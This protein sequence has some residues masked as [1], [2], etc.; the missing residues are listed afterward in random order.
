MPLEIKKAKEKDFLLIIR[1]F[2]ADPLSFLLWT[3]S[4][5]EFENAKAALEKNLKESKI[6]CFSVFL[7]EELVG[8][9]ELHHINRKW[10]RL[11]RFVVDPKK[12]RRG[13]GKWLINFLAKKFRST[14]LLRLDLVVFTE[15]YNAIRLYEGCGFKTEGILKNVGQVEGRLLN[16]KVMS[17]LGNTKN[18][19]ETN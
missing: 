18:G 15:N 1:W 17:I 6:K 14:S 2:N 7:N 10:I 16:I 4:D 12:R 5:F 3:G 19:K 8:Y 11:V 13:L 9:Y